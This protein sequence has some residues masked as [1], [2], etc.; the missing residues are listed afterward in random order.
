MGL[1]E[2]GDHR[3]R[4]ALGLEDS[5][6]WGPSKQSMAPEPMNNSSKLCT[7]SWFFLCVV[8]LV[9]DS[10]P[11]RSHK[12][13]VLALP[14]RKHSSEQLSAPCSG[15]WRLFWFPEKAGFLLLLVHACT[16]TRTQTPAPPQT[17]KK[18]TPPIWPEILI[19]ILGIVFPSWASFL[20]SCQE[21]V[22]PTLGSIFRLC[23]TLGLVLILGRFYP[24]HFWLKYVRNWRVVAERRSWGWQE[25]LKKDS[26]C[27]RTPSSW[28]WKTQVFF[29]FKW[30]V[31]S[32][33]LKKK[34]TRNMYLEEALYGKEFLQDQ[35]QVRVWTAQVLGTPL[36]RNQCESSI[37]KYETWGPASGLRSVLISS[38]RNRTGGW[39]D[40]LC[41]KKGD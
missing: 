9:R 30:Q 40:F 8:H 17:N 11:W 21:A 20:V 7:G 36:H 37:G 18:P 27:H 5:K 2:G 23:V 38:S 19:F 32:Q 28:K 16:H 41:L 39:K 22:S 26:I 25:G 10:C 6:G 34:E 4:E 33:L 35:Q 24:K 31:P 3:G 13:E 12:R 15:D 29:F 1:E 14:A